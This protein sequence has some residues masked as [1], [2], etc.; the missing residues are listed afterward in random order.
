MRSDRR[1]ARSACLDAEYAA[2]PG[3]GASA[4]IE[5]VTT[6]TPAVRSSAGSAARTRLTAPRNVTSTVRSKSSFAA[7]VNGPKT[8]AAAFETATSRPPHSR[9]TVANRRVHGVLVG[10]VDREDE[11][12]GAGPPDALGD[13]LEPLRRPREHRHVVARVGE[14]ERRGGA[15]PARCSGDQDA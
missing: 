3:S 9:S 7:S 15:D 8:I 6:S 4:L 11:T 5:P 13:A 1:N 14:G 2:K 10:D 12:A